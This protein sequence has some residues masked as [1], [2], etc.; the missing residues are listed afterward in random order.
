M[1]W[2][3]LLTYNKYC[4]KDGKLTRSQSPQVLNRAHQGAA[5]PNHR[6]EHETLPRPQTQ[7]EDLPGPQ[8]LQREGPGV[9][10]H[11]DDQV[12]LDSREAKGCRGRPLP[13]Y[14]HSG[15]L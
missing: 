11:R 5:F 10:H 4:R 9:Q 12:C 2:N 6:P 14:E 8:G 13:L 15:A 3:R 7:N 1:F